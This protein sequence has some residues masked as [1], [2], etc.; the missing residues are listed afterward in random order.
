MTRRELRQTV[1]G[2]SNVV[3]IRPKRETNVG[4]ALRSCHIFG[5]KSIQ[6][7]QGR[8]FYQASNTSR[9]ERHSPMFLS[10][11][12]SI[13]HDCVPVAVEVVDDSISLERYQHPA[14]ALYIFGPEDGSI[15]REI[16]ARCRDVVTIPGAFCLNLASAVAVLLYDR[17]AKRLRNAA[18]R[19]P[20][21][22]EVAS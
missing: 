20:S 1:R 12:L 11:E 16:M 14:S 15:P 21:V 9:A 10:D 6:I 2:Q 22:G 18:G 7:I 19:W 3:L 8:Y 4:T 5:V 17:E 13:P